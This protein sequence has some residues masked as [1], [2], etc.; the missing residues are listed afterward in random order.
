MAGIPQANFLEGIAR[1]I[2]NGDELINAAKLLYDDESYPSS[3]FIAYQ[4]IEEYG[5]AILLIDDMEKEIIEIS[6]NRWDNLYCSHKK[7]LARIR[8]AIEEHLYEKMERSEERARIPLREV[9]KVSTEFAFS[10]K[11]RNMYVN[12]DFEKG[13]WVSPQ[14]VIDSRIDAMSLIFFARNTKMALEIILEKSSL[15]LSVS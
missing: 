1:S 5:K 12:W 4:G 6:K 11:I 2:I 15:R 7:K 3:V 13:S 14:D 10:D 8:K 9:I